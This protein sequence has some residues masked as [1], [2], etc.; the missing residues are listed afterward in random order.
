MKH[1]LLKGKAWV[2]GDEINSDVMAPG[3]YF[4]ESMDVMA[5]H[6]LEAIDPLFAKEVRPGD[7]VVAGR[8]F[9]VGSAREQAALA[10]KELKVGAIIAKSYAR[11][12]YRNSLNFGL[13]A[14]ISEYVN[15]IR[16]KDELIINPVL[17]ELENLTTKKNIIISP[18][19]EHLMEMISAG[20]L[21]PYLKEKIDNGEIEV[22]KK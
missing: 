10:F 14:L 6:C 20:G 11:I 8:N 7:I 15:E 2:F 9:G 5:S 13:P 18:I 3:I 21:M 4:K 22:R 17:G 16:P 1:K 12:F 19:P